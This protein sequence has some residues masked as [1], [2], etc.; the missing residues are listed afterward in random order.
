MRTVVA[1]ELLSL[2]GVAEEPSDWMSDVDDDVVANL[3]TTTATQDLVLLGR[4]TYDHWAG[5]WPTSDVQPFARFI[6]AT[7]EHV[8]TSRALT[9]AW[10]GSSPV[11]GD[12]VEHVSRLRSG[13]SGDIGVHGSLQLVRSS[14]A[15]GVVD[16]L[17]LVVTGGVAGSGRRLLDQPLPP[18]RWRLLESRASA[19]GALLLHYG[20]TSA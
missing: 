8:I 11:H 7:D 6:N 16:E 10:R 14:L 19:S 13:D 2:D 20:R 9:P 4:G 5:Y 15:A 12:A 1:Y 3:A 17:R 18:S